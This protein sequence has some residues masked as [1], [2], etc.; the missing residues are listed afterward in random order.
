LSEAPDTPAETARR[1]RLPKAI[2]AV[3]VVLALLLG[4]LIMGARYGV[5]LP[6]A[7]LLI[8]ARTDGL[9][10][11]SFGQIRIEGLSGDIW[12]DFR[13]RRLTIRDEKGVWLEA[14]NVRMQWRYVELL[15]RRFH[16]DKI[17][18]EQ[19]R[20]IRRPT[21]G[22]KGKEGGL[23]V[24][25]YIDAA[26]AR[27]EM[28]PEFSFR[29]GLYD[30][31]MNL[32]VQRSGGQR[33]VVQAASLLNPG[34][35]LNVQFEITKQ[36]P[37]LILAD[38]VEA[39][40]GAIAGALGLPADQPFLL[41]VSAGG[42][43]SE[44]H[45]TALAVSGPNRP[46]E[47]SGAWSPQGGQVNGRISLTASSLTA[48]YAQRVGPEV[49]VTGSGRK[50]EGDLYALDLQA[51]AENLELRAQGLGDV[52]ARKLGPQG[53]TVTATSNQL[54][55]LTGGPAMG[56]TVMT[57][58]LKG[59]A[60][61][62]RFAGTAAV[63]RLAFGG[64][65]LDQMSGPFEIT[66]NA[67]ALT[68]KA[69]V[70]GRGGR[71][72]GW[73]PAVMGGAPR[74][75]LE[76]ARF[77]DGRLA[78][79]DL[80]VLGSGL[81]VQ[82]SGGRGLLG[83]L[84]LKGQAD[85]SNLSAAHAGAGGAAQLVWS[86][87]QSRA[88][89]PWAIKLDAEGAKLTTGYPELDRLLGP[90]P[91][92][93]AQGG[94][95]GRRFSLA[96]ADLKGA[97]ITAT[98]A[99]VMAEDG[100]LSFKLDWSADGPFHAGPVEILGRAKG[101]GALTG[102]L[103]SPRADLMAEFAEID[104]PQLP[105]K[106]ARLTLSFLRKPDGSSGMLAA[107]AD[108]GYGPARLSTDFR[109]P[110]GGVD[111]TNLAVDA[112]GVKAGGSVALHRSGPSAANL[113]L[114]IG[115]GAFLEAGKVGGVVKIIDGPGGAH[116]QIHLDAEGARTPGS[117]TTLLTARLNADG[118]ITQLLYSLDIRGV[119]GIGKFGAAGGGVFSQTSPGY[120]ATFEGTGG[121]GGHVL[122]TTEPAQVRIAG[123]LRSAKVSLASTDGGRLSLDGQLTDKDA[124]VRAQ[125]V[126]VRLNMLSP[127]LAGRVDA[128]LVL[129]GR[130]EH[131]DGDLQAR[132]DNARG[133][134]APAASGV[135]SEIR[136]KLAGKTLS[137]DATATNAQGL[138]ANASVVLPTETSAAPFRLAIAHKE[139][140]QG[141]F[142]ASGEVRPLW[143]LLVGG[144]RT[145]AGTV[146]AQGTLSG[147]LADPQAVGEISM[148]NG[149]FED[150][151]TGLSLRNMTMKAN[152][153]RNAVDVTQANAVDGH[154]GSVTG[155]G[156]I[157]LEREGV[158]SFRLDL[159]RF[160]LIDNEQGT[161][162]AS[163]QV[164][165]NR[166]ADGKVTL[167]GALTIDRADIAPHVPSGASV[168][169]M[170][171][172]EKN[173][174]PEL[175]AREPVST[176]SRDGSAGWGLDISLRA[177]ERVYLRGKGLDVELSLDAHVG[178]TTAAPQLSGRAEV[179]RGDYDF[180]GKRFDFDTS[181]VVFL[182]TRPQDI[183]LNLTATRQD[184]SLTAI[185]K[186]TGTA[187]K[188]EIAFSSIPSLPDDE[189]LSQVLFGTS[190]SQLSPIEAAQLAAAVSSLATGG[191][192]DV[193]G[194]LRA[195]AGLDR[196]SLGGNETT[197]VTVAGGKYI[198]RNI[199]LE[200]SGGAREGPAAQVEWRVRRTLSIISRVA[201]ESGSKLA[202]RWRRDY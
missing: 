133:R 99:G 160:R 159:R 33:G 32:A 21:L 90:S 94:L 110:E 194:N 150:G 162:S 78:L 65:G 199:Y 51:R 31:R 43:T 108:S 176:A 48:P 14:Q 58:V 153:A 7:R 79:R 54:S 152:F 186:I 189:V 68:V 16:A 71:G 190:A 171:V 37:L 158:S 40:G 181:S 187:A 15:F 61:A 112:G 127:D 88:G 164:T 41:R 149:R 70:A 57:A 197:G 47:A 22:P 145:L 125:L 123:P 134:G 10:I 4:A 96:R 66:R 139:P 6:Q 130:G 193:I 36:R 98:S 126:G 129:Q 173:R 185:V 64:Y 183:R 20:L 85:V 39:R 114:A 170:D 9:K 28:L 44:G 55:R 147:T 188:P 80:E 201:G 165:M 172:I 56:P 53:I 50:A 83:G 74:A 184:P 17:E 69:N 167:A 105:L 24:S 142:A 124:E 52:G 168:V 202:V 89:E 25:F 118:P 38:A 87:G 95:Q 109:F 1:S 195:F 166:A 30:L 77:N 116:A 29:R 104:V 18:I 97:A 191:G 49:R 67:S 27:V 19:L 161:A 137:L 198:S 132:L 157:S 155:S 140:L 174:P 3:C 102:P 81:R 163:G 196:L 35:H 60:K 76:A 175:I 8:E 177:P 117:T 121:F 119:G 2:V 93:A 106:N 192:L 45:F 86:A 91:R 42:R 11:G 100:A 62:W 200:V 144:E 73:V 141:R 138:K 82:A 63:Q 120:A 101:N 131:L 180:A 136:G 72:T 113:T 182:A 135:N 169:S 111:L 148:A 34:D 12:R 84:T 23:P 146:Q 143:D 103:A 46:I 5:L 179:V 156:R 26:H 107:T 92:L 59:D 128:D 115:P 13:V 75:R 122:R 151:A 178:G 154:D